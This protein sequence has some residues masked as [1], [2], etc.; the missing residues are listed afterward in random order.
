MTVNTAIFAVLGLLVKDLTL[1]GWEL[2]LVSLP[3]FLVGMLACWIWREIIRQYRVL[4]GWRYEQLVEIEKAL[5]ESHQMYLKE[6]KRFYRPQKERKRF[7]F[8]RLEAWLPG[9][10]LGGSGSFPGGG[11]TGAPGVLAARHLL[12]NKP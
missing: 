5:P 1:R 11:L 8:S 3:L 12:E 4:I 7:G 6:W 9:L 2:V 10:F